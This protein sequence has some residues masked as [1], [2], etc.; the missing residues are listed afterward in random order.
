MS[1]L[2]NFGPPKVMQDDI[3]KQGLAKVAKMGL[4]VEV[5]LHSTVHAVGIQISTRYHSIVGE[6]SVQATLS[7]TDQRSALSVTKKP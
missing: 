2:E 5:K 6:L 3:V 4:N 1:T 7:D